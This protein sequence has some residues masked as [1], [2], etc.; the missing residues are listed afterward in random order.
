MLNIG[1]SDKHSDSKDKLSQDLEETQ[2]ELN[3]AR[4]YF[5]SVSDPDLI[6][7]AIYLLEAAQKKYTYLLKKKKKQ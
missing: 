4:R 1:C 6:D 7:H 5:N 3:R 2:K